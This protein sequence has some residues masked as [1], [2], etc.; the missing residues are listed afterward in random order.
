MAV[1]V[2]GVMAPARERPSVPVGRPTPHS[3]ATPSSTRTMDDLPLAALCHLSGRK[4]AFSERLALRGT[5]T[6]GPGLR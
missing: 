6:G 2:E 4:I 5:D 1:L 3:I